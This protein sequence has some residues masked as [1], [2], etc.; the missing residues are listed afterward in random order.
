MGQRHEQTALSPLNIA[1]VAHLS[2]I[3][4]ATELADKTGADHISIDDGTL[5]CEANHKTALR[6]HQQHPADW[7]IILEDDAD[8]VDEFRHQLAEALAVA[9]APL[10]SLYLGQ[11]HP[12]QHQHAIKDA[13]NRAETVDACWITSRNLLHGVGYAIRHERITSLLE[14]TSP[15]PSSQHITAWARRHQIPV[16]YTFPSLVDHLDITPLIQHRH[17]RLTR[18]PGRKAWRV[19]TRTEWTTTSTPM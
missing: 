3:S 17:D 8:P 14:H 18:Q 5:G 1:V 2:R 19:G 12:P 4:L 10:I 11:K 16:A 13:I 7:A 15:L 6:W 9:P